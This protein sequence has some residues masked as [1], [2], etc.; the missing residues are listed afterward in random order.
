MRR[1]AS[2]NHTFN[3]GAESAVRCNARLDGTP[4]N[5]RHSSDNVGANAGNRSAPLNGFGSRSRSVGCS[6]AHVENVS[7]L[8]GADV[9]RHLDGELPW[10][11]LL[12]GPPP[13]FDC[14]QRVPTS[15]NHLPTRN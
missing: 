11:T 9:L 15:C 4:R 8:G 3:G 5:R 2:N 13:P 10:P 1:S 6:L 7:G 14:R 12:D